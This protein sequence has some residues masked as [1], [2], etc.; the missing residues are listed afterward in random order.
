MRLGELLRS[1]A[2]S[3]P[4]R[5]AEDVKDAAPSKEAA[6]SEELR[7]LPIGEVRPSPYQARQA[8]SGEELEQL[9]QSIREHGVLQ[10]VVV[11]A[12]EGGYELIAGE[13]RWRAAR[14]AGLERIP[15][16]V[17]Q[18]DDRTAAEWGLIENMQ[19]SGL[20]F[21]EEA[22]G[23]RR[24]ME[25]FGLTQEELARFVGCSQAAVANKVRLLR[26][27]EE[28]RSIIRT[29]GLGERQ[30]RALLRL[31]DPRLQAEA[32]TKMGKQGLGA[33]ASERL[34][35]QMLKGQKRPRRMRGV[36][37]DARIF[38]NGLRQV[39]RQAKQSGLDADLQEQEDGT[40]WTFIVRLG[41]KMQVRQGRAE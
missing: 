24:M 29:S 25:Q 11:R 3:A 31:D 26:L 12:V 22:E 33:E 16:I 13:R 8:I 37:G 7:W 30:S 10:P 6:P 23:Y 28:V 20:H 32:A 40:G 39:V 15:A 34:V 2:T 1:R 38:V 27:P 19:R 21:L 36:Y 35:D 5:V 18:A 4:R 17:K 14:V 9:A 41:K